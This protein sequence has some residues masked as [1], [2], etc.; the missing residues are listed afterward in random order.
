MELDRP[1]GLA[2]V[3]SW[4]EL[5]KPGE[6]CSVHFKYENISTLPL[7]L[8]EVWTIK[9]SGHG[10]LVCRYSVEPSNSTYVS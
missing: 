9:N 2:V 5:V 4:D 1:L 8:L 6:T 7:R 10:R 3:S